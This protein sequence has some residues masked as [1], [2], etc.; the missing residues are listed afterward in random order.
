VGGPKD[1]HGIATAVRP[2]RGEPKLIER[3]R[4]DMSRRVAS[5]MPA[6]RA[7]NFILD[8]THGLTAMATKGR[9]F[10]A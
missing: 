4:C 9:A 10:G 7:S 8:S 6:P 3:R 1:R 2:W 5:F